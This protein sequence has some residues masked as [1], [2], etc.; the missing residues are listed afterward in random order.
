MN[1]I[2]CE[3]DLICLV[4]HLIHIKALHDIASDVNVILMWNQTS[5]LQ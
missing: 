3:Q 5:H 4:L 2:I 1:L